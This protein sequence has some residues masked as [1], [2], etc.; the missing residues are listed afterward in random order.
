MRTLLPF[1]I[2]EDYYED[3]YRKNHVYR[4]ITHFMSNL[5]LYYSYRFSVVS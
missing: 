2:D 4:N 1:P 5:D 3:Y